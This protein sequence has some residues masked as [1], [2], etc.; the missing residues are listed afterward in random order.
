VADRARPWFGRLA[1]T[2]ALLALAPF[3]RAGETNL[4][5]EKVV[6]VGS[7]FRITIAAEGPDDV[8]L[9]SELNPA[10]L[11]NGI[12]PRTN[13]A[14]KRPTSNP[15]AAS[16]SAAEP[17]FPPLPEDEALRSFLFTPIQ[18]GL[19]FLAI[20]RLRGNQVEKKFL[21]Y[22]VTI[23]PD[24]QQEAVNRAIARKKAEQKQKMDDEAAAFLQAKQL[25]TARYHEAALR[26]ID[27]YLSKYPAGSMSH[28][29]TR[30]KGDVLLLMTNF[31]G[32]VAN[33]EEY[34]KKTEIK[35]SQR[36]DALASLGEAYLSIKQPAQAVEQ[37]LRLATRYKDSPRYP[38]AL[39]ALGALL[40]GEKRWAAAFPYFEAFY[41]LHRD[42]GAAQVPRLDEAIF[43]MAQVY[44]ND[45]TRRDMV[46]AVEFYQLL[47]DKAPFSAMVPE[48][49]KRIRYLQRNFLDVR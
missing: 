21:Y 2:A 3:L 5:Q 33:Y 41:Q 49:K 43:G 35:D 30:L 40:S 9:V 11:S 15:E 26:E 19:T 28:Q 39:L 47:L 31:A 24:S 13:A 6:L 46:K 8:F 7:P 44:E 42:K 29:A 18:P 22:R 23:L 48:A 10:Y 4:W 36:A 12:V 34:L 32:A 37:Y 14:K 1:L 20:D 27:A 17:A 45:A 25:A 16:N 38:D